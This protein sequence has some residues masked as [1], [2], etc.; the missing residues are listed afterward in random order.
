MEFILSFLVAGFAL[1]WAASVWP[2][3]VFED[4]REVWIDVLALA[5]ALVSQVAIASVAF[6]AI[7]SV[8]HVEAVSSS[9]QYLRTLSPV[10]AAL[11]YFLVVDFLAYWMHRLNHVRWLWPTHAFHHSARNVYWAS[12]MRGSPVHFVLLGVPSLLVQVVFSPEGPVLALVLAYGVVHNSLIHSN[13]R[14]PG[15]A[16]NWLF[17]TGES[18][19]VHHG[20][21][22]RLGGSNFGFLFTFWDRLFGTW[23]DPRSLAPNHPLGLDYE[24]GIA[25][26]VLGLPVAGESLARPAAAES[27]VRHENRF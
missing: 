5:V 15:R 20:R 25:R 2:V 11:F 21:D 4:G 22:P 14:I 23:T 7:S 9:Y 8:Q 12:G 3:R 10:P 6:P 18:H 26:L 27:L 19:M 24:I 1:Q 13:L 16:L 17:V